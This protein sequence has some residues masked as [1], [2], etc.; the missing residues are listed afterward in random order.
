MMTTTVGNYPKVAQ[1]AYGTKLKWQRQELAGSQLEDAYREV[2]RAVI[3]EQEQAGLDLLTDGQVR[4]DDLLR[5]VAKA[6]DGFEMNGLTRWFNN[7]VYYRRPILHKAPVRRGPILVED[8]QF[9]SSCTRK[10][11]KVVLP[12]PYTFAVLSEDRH[13]KKLR[14]LALKLAELLNAEARDLAAAGAPFIQFDEPAIGFG[15]IDLKLVVEALNVAV[16][17]VPAKT[18]VSTYFGALDGAFGALM[19][20]AVQVVGVDVVSEPRTLKA[21]ASAPIAKELALGCLD[22]RNTKLE[23]VPQLHRLFRMVSRRVSSDRLYINPNTGLE[24]LPHP[25]ALAKIRRL[26]EA[27]RSYQE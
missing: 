1:R 16:R 8:Y 6:L 25:Q 18:A 20:S 12:G 10:P 17:G 15:K 21:L 23:E 24:F 14:P 2:T 27:V 3:Q 4:W 22:A 26:V 11:V 9:A 5:P 19:K 13:Y 7:N